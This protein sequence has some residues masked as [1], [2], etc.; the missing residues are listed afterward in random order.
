MEDRQPAMP[1]FL[2]YPLPGEKTA[3]EGAFSTED[4]LYQQY[5]LEAK[6]ALQTVRQVLDG[7]DF[8]ENYIYDEY[9]DRLSLLRL[10]EI[11]LRQIP[12]SREISRESQR[13][14]VQL[15]LLQEL[16]RRRQA[17]EE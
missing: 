12:I 11:I 6:K 13:E 3:K 15:L 5:P 8:G 2:T 7:I 1:Y 17:K 4:Y 14:M 9:P 16:M 10:A